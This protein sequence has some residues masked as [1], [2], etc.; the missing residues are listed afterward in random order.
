MAEARKPRVPSG[1]AKI[2]PLGQVIASRKLKKLPL[3]EDATVYFGIPRPHP[4]GDWV[5]PFV[6]EEN[7][8][9]EAHHA[10]GIDSFQALQLAIEG[11]R[12]TLDKRGRYAQFE[13]HPEGGPGINK[14][15]PTNMDRLFEERVVLALER[16][17][18]AYYARV[19][20][21]RRLDV[22]AL[23]RVVKERRKILTSLEGRISEQKKFLEDWKADLKKWNPRITAIRPSTPEK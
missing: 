15:I 5:C 17:S 11:A 2:T 13:S 3:F 7:G 19:A 21:K 14:H 22:N 4:K 16:E 9:R 20:K 1:F 18:K 10:F 8:K 6:I 23:E 12:V